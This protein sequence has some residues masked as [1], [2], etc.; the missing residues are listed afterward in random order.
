[1]QRPKSL[2]DVLGE[3]IGNMGIG[4]KLDEARAI[5]AWY[6]VAGAAVNEVTERV[7]IDRK[8]MFVKVSSSVWRQELHLQRDTWLERIHEEAGVEVVR[9]IVF[10]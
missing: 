7:W 10:R 2:N 8:K 9:E 4:R 1:M 3:V 6:H 5:E